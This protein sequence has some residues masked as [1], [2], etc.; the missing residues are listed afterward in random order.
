[1]PRS[2]WASFQVKISIE[3]YMIRI[4]VSTVFSE[5]KEIPQMYGKS[6]TVSALDLWVQSRVVDVTFGLRVQYHNPMQ[7]ERLREKTRG[8]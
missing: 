5:A 4:T 2:K 3:S 7:K 1:M 8:Y 6:R